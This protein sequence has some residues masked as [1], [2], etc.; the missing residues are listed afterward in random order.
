MNDA[1]I[2][3]KSRNE[4]NISGEED[5]KTIKKIKP[6]N[7]NTGINTLIIVYFGGTTG[8]GIGTPSSTKTFSVSAVVVIWRIVPCR[9][10]SC[11][12]R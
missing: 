9:E 11:I 1:A 4:F 12:T 7:R 8:S 5:R 6:K 3:T 2:R 10:E